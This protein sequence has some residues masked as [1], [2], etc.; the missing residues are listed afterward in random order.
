ML[1]L[2]FHGSPEDATLGLPRFARGCYAWTSTGVAR[3][4]YAFA[5]TGTWK[6]SYL[7]EVLEKHCIP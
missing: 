2:D 1:R 6:F 4:R 7:K 5:S 3:G